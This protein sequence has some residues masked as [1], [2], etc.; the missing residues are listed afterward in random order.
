[1]LLRARNPARRA[2]ARRILAY[3]Q[4]YRT[5]VIA[6]GALTVLGSLLSIVP[7]V[8]AKALI[9]RITKPE[10]H[11]SA[12]LAPVGFA[13]AGAM[14]A[15]V[16]G[17]V[18]SYL[19]ESV[20]EGIVFDL[21]GELFNHLLGQG[22]AFYT[23]NRAG[24]LLSRMLGDIGGIDNTL[25]T[26]LLALAQALLNCVAT[27][28]LMIVLDWRLTLVALAVLP[29]VALP[30][31]RAGAR[32]SRARLAVQEQLAAMTAYLQ[33][34]LGL[35]GML[36]VRVFGRQ[37]A[38]RDRF[39][40]L[41]TEM[42]RRE[43]AAAMTIRVF[44]VGITLIGSLAPLTILLIGGLLIV[45]HE[46]SVGTV[47]VFAT[48]VV[49]RL[50]NSLQGAASSSAA[51]LGSVALWRRIFETLDTHPEVV[52]RPGAR[53]LDAARPSIRLE[54]VTF[55]YPGQRDPAVQD[56]SFEVEPG[57]L[58]AIVGPSGAG[59]TTLAALIARLFD[60]DSGRVLLG[61]HDV[62][63][64]TLASLSEAVGLVQQETFLFHATLRE[65]L[66]YGRPDATEH[67]LAEAVRDAHLEEVVARLPD[68]YDTIVGERGHRLSGGEKQRVAIA[69]TM[70]RD[71]GIL[72]LDEA[73]SHLDSVSER[74]VQQGLNRLMHGRTAVVIAHR[75][76]T[77]L[78]A[79]VLLVLDQGH[80]VERGT[81]DELVRSGGL[82]AQLHALQGTAVPV[83]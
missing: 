43:I 37:G 67:E 10:L 60:P 58:I 83:V 23:R 12:L 38:E 2:L 69:R 19:V 72:I 65:N 41:N 74:I 51:T 24:D 40:A 28:V 62:R 42:R 1:V 54:Q 13:L 27:F 77:V 6:A 21:R 73:T 3:V 57:Q 32:T 68:G 29:L 53:A 81:H 52:Q 16:L 45:H 18:V 78:S 33:E 5:T 14:L 34:T 39:L 66:L 4:P 61:G 31:R 22:A 55:R 59:K 36:L 47:L 20:S 35:S 63:D 17:T 80:V 70:I 50:A 15:A 48:V 82:Y 79:D 25:S 49:A 44:T 46:A 64:L 56:V 8:A 26:T 7:M 75:L 71:P 9:D 76:S 11:F 30:T